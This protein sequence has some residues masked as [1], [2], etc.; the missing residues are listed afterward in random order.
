MFA[1][2]TLFFKGDK[3]HGDDG[4]KLKTCFP[5]KFFWPSIVI[6]TY[7]MNQQDALFST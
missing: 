2:L 7:N 6:Y 1:Y 5:L 3:Q 4:Y